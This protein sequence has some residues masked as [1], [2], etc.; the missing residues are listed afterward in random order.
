[1][2]N[3]FEGAWDLVPKEGGF[4][5]PGHNVWCAS[6]IEGED[7]KFHLFASCWEEKYG[8][9]SNWLLRSK[10][11]HAVS[12]TPEG[13]YHFHSF[14]FDRRDRAYFDAMSQ[15]NPNIKF[16]DGIYYLYYF[17][18]T[19]SGDIPKEDGNVSNERFVEI[20]NC[21]RIG[22]ATATS[23][24][25]P[26]KRA[27]TPLLE[28]RNMNYWDCTCTTN[29]S[30]AILPNGKTYMI[31]KSRRNCES[32]LQLGVAVSNR[33]DGIFTRLTDAPIFSFEN[34]NWFV[35]DPFIWYENGRFCLLMKDDF[36]DSS[37]GITGE[38]GAGIYAESEDC[39]HWEIAKRPKAYS[40]TLHW[41]DGSVTIQSHLERPNIL[42]QNGKPTHVFAATGSGTEP[43]VFDGATWN[44]CMPLLV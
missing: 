21:K 15:H 28:P 41:S 39:I 14:V 12:D 5:F 19:Y 10:I 17:G 16:H 24:Y 11:A 33:P 23:V 8:F 29:P 13:P 42:F 9:G 6:A 35:E 26:W 7:K 44:V 38:W 34:P 32:P 22:V 31:Y 43:W 37:G 18:T 25:G 27:E 2:V 3:R 20:W 4:R 36:R 40:R 1:M 30:V